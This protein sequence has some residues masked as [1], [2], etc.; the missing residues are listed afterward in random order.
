M[1]SN[2]MLQGFQNISHRLE[3]NRVPHCF[4]TNLLLDEPTGRLGI[5]VPSSEGFEQAN[6]SLFLFHYMS[7]FCLN[8]EDVML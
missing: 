4:H 2:S 3:S 6:R 1:I 7:H 5:E 8:C